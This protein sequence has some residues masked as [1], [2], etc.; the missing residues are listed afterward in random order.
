MNDVKG[1]SKHETWNTEHE[2]FWR[3]IQYTVNR[4][5]VGAQ[6]A[7]LYGILYGCTD[8]LQLERTVQ[9][10]KDYV[11]AHD[12]STYIWKLLTTFL[13]SAQQEKQETVVKQEKGR[14]MGHDIVFYGLYR[15][16]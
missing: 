11:M 2:V 10:V 13:K 8:K 16:F 12:S 1:I 9:T 5:P 7:V 15:T 6:C 14:V 3:C 4:Q